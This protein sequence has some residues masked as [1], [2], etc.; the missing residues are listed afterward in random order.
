M[1]LEGSEQTMTIGMQAFPHALVP[2]PS[3]PHMEKDLFLQLG[4]L[5]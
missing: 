2:A 1:H 4:M 5:G 3:P